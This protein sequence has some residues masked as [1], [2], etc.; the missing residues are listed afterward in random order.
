MRK[1]T[2]PEWTN[3]LPDSANL[4]TRD[5]L[6]AFGYKL[7]MKMIS[8][9]IKRKSIPEPDI[10]MRTG[11]LNTIHFYWKLGTLREIVKNQDVK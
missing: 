11:S 4:N 2:L 3:D 1:I 5:V 7:N 6:E 8:N 10:K 9:L